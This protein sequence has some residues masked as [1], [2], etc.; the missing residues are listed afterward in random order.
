MAVEDDG[1]GGEEPK[2]GG[3]GEEWAMRALVGGLW[4][5]IS[6]EGVPLTQLAGA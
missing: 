3:D 6:S 2:L 1:R 4:G 5:G